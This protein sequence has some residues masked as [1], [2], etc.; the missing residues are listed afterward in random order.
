MTIDF[1]LKLAGALLVV[2]GLAHSHFGRYFKWEKELAR[3]SLLT[4][5]IF[6]VH[7]FFIS[8]SIILLGGC[9]LF[10][11]DALLR[12]GGLS[13]IVLTNIVV[14]WGIRL[15]CQLFVYDAAIWRGH[16]FY[17]CM[18]VVFCV[19]WTYIVFTYGAALRIAWRE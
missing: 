12:S 11:T 3:L 1:Q 5:Q 19:F 18:H 7:C 9:T 8:L 16:R 2:L 14:F 13:R 10:Y 17:T 4:R 15:V 6:Q